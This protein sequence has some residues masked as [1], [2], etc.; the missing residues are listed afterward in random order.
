M[1][2]RNK[3][4]HQSLLDQYNELSDKKVELEKINRETMQAGSQIDYLKEEIKE[5]KNERNLLQ[6]EFDNIMKQPFFKKENDQNSLNKLQELEAKIAQSEAEIKKS[7]AN[8]LK[9]EEDIKESSEE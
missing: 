5:A 3:E 9:H 4:F 8:I 7:R 2:L 6:K 1:F